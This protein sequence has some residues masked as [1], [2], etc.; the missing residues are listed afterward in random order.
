MLVALAAEF[1]RINLTLQLLLLLLQ[2]QKKH[3]AFI[4]QNYSKHVF[5][6]DTHTHTSVLTASKISIPRQNIRKKI[7]FPA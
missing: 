7:E 4:C 6:Q 2:I 3:G 1:M 5:N